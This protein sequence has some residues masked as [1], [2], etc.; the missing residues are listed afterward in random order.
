[1]NRSRKF[2]KFICKP[3]IVYNNIYVS[4]IINNVMKGGNK[5]LA[6]KIV[7]KAI[8]MIKLETD[9]EK[10]EYISKAIENV[11][12]K[13][14]LRS[15][16]IASK[17]YRVPVSINDYRSYNIAIKWIV[18]SAMSNKNSKDKDASYL[19]FQEID[20]SYKSISSAYKKKEQYHAVAKENEVYLH[21]V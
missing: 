17:V 3:D 19:L 6:C 18:S 21:Y 20:N 10:I 9:D 15:K 7:Y 1:M 11:R 13:C 8:D 2:N 12:P 14:Y 16:R 4:K 5:S